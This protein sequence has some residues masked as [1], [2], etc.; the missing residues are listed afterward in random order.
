MENEVKHMKCWG[1]KYHG[2]LINQG[3]MLCYHP[4]NCFRDEESETVDNEDYGL[5]TDQ[6]KLYENVEKQ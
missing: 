4:K 1:C 2:H 5:F 3:V 6:C